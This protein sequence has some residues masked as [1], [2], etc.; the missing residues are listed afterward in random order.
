MTEPEPKADDPMRARL[1]RISSGLRAGGISA[2]VLATYHH[3]SGT[4]PFAFQRDGLIIDPE[5]VARFVP[6]TAIKDS[7]Y[8][9]GTLLREDKQ[10]RIQGE[11]SAATLPLRLV[12]DE[13]LDLPLNAHPKGMS[14]RLTIANLIE[15]QVR[16]AHARILRAQE[17][18]PSAPGEGGIFP[19]G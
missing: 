3:E 17:K 18:A 7:T 8:Y 14:E 10:R 15:Q 13:V 19:S 12:G 11:R 2:D 4:R 5:G 6:F 9:D 16:L 1:L